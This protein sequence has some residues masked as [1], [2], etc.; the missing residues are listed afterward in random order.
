MF[1]AIGLIIAG[2]VIAVGGH[3]INKKVDAWYKSKEDKAKELS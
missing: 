1:H 3:I 2:L